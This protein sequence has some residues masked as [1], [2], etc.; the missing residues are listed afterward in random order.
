[1]CCGACVDHPRRGP[2]EDASVATLL[3]RAKLTERR[4][5]KGVVRKVSPPLTGSRVRVH[6]SGLPGC[7]SDSMGGLD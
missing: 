4:V 3:A 7:R 2:K 6:P 5:V 1:M